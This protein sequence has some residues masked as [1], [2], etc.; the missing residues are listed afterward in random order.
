MKLISMV[1]PVLRSWSGE[2]SKD[3][4][5]MGRTLFTVLQ[6]LTILLMSALFSLWLCTTGMRALQVAAASVTEN[7]VMFARLRLSLSVGASS[8]VVLNEIV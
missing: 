1:M 4:V 3:T 8:S 2:R 7:V 6:D 5:M